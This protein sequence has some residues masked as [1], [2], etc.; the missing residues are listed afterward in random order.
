MLTTRMKI[1]MQFKIYRDFTKHIRKNKTVGPLLET[2]G[3]VIFAFGSSNGGSTPMVKTGKL[4]KMGVIPKKKKVS[5]SMHIHTVIGKKIPKLLIKAQRFQNEGFK[6][7][8]KKVKILHEKARKRIEKRIENLSTA[9]LEAMQREKLYEPVRAVIDR[10]LK[11][12]EPSPGSV[13]IIE[14]FIL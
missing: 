4:R 1:D 6:G 12:R 11:Y 3:F 5:L 9:A 13:V 14:I 7:F 10:I 2:G 8:E